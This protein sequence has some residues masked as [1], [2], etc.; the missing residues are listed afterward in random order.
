MQ[1]SVTLP[2]FNHAA[3]IAQAIEG[4]LSQ[5][6]QDWQLCIVDD[7][8]TDDSW[9]IIE[10]YRDRDAR[11]V[12]ARLPRN[13]GV[14]AALRRCHELCTGELL[15][16]LASDDY[17]AN[18]RFFEL[19]V[20]ALQ[21]FPQAAIAYGRAAIIDGG[22]GRELGWMGC[23]IPRRGARAGAMNG[24]MASPMQ[25]VPPREALTRFVSHHMF[26][27]GCGVILRRALMAELGLG[28]YDEALGPQSDY[29]LHHALAALHGAAFIDT[30]V[31]GARVS[32][33][34]YSGS[35]KD[36]DFFRWQAL[37][38]KKLR[39]LPLP[40]ET[41]ERLWAQ[42]RTATIAS[43][44]AEFHQRR[45]FDTLRGFCDSVPPA[46]R[47]MFP[48]EP[49]AFVGKLEEECAHLETNLNSKIE[50]ARQIFNDVAGPVEALP[51]G[52]ESSP[53]RW[54]RPV[55]EFFLSLGKILGKTFT[56]VGNWLW[57]V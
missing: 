9:T 33:T 34:T 2:N 48:P 39:A 6:Y 28:Y 51:L 42:F 24:A 50:R 41:D 15:S 36:D 53:R 25:F 8:S 14:H 46:E 40:Y 16:P 45:L 29:F 26:I 55:A 31:A 37:V 27:P 56:G 47:Q 38:E 52:S 54:L 7:G 49:A 43:R 5:T 3:Y 1:I 35:A 4:V 20:A 10:R 13:S 17:Y 32:A 23:Y 19:G 11:I 21:R 44:T 22:D 30:P 57:Q 12:A 18:P